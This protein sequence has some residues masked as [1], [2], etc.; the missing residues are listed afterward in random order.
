MQRMI[1]SASVKSVLDEKGWDQKRLAKEVGVSAQAVTNWFKGVDFP[2]PDKLL[3]LSTTLTMPF[4]QM[5]LTPGIELPVVAFR[6][7]AGTKT[8]QEHLQRAQFIGALLRPLVGYLPGLKALRTLIPAPTTLYAELQGAV[9]SVRQKL[10]LG[11]ETV[12]SYA[13]LIKEFA[14]NDAVIVPVMWGVKQK[15]ENALHILLRTENVTFIFLNLDSHL[16]DFKFWMAHE[17]A[18]VFTPNLAGTDE[19][20]D[21]ADAFAGALLFPRDLAQKAYGQAAHKQTASSQLEVLQEYARAHE[22]SLYNVFC[23]VRKYT[24]ALDL[25]ALKI[26]DKSI[27]AVRTMKRG[28]LVSAVL[29]KPSPPDPATYIASARNTF[30]SSFF[31]ALKRMVLEKGTGAGYIQQILDSSITDAR[32]LHDEIVR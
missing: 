22:I 21:F 4:A 5:V 2:R 28:E 19:G 27:H 17:L 15:H 30:Q 23:E 14:A 1:N 29:F 32:A 16:E 7:R 9:A 3:K 11:P 12:V 13:H 25:P 20:E 31:D 10:G 6:K 24:K 18:H 8:T 26:V